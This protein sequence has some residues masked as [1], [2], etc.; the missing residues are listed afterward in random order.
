MMPF[1]TT[2]EDGTL[3]SGRYS[4]ICKTCR[5]AAIPASSIPMR[6][7]GGGDGIREPE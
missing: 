3:G 7:R 1:L 5:A 6:E 4:P 2:E